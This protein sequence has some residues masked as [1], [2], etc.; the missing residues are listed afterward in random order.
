MRYDSRMN[1]EK[2]PRWSTRGGSAIEEPSSGSAGKVD[3]RNTL[4]HELVVDLWGCDADVLQS[5]DR[6]RSILE[7]LAGETVLDIFTRRFEPNGII[8]MALATDSHIAIH[9]RPDQKY[10]AL[11]IYS[12]RDDIPNALNCACETMKASRLHTLPVVRGICSDVKPAVRP[13][14]AIG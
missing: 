5:A 14:A 2:R 4:G 9:T 11:T 1:M 12:K 8:G 6:V 13:E 3:A 10:A 7:T